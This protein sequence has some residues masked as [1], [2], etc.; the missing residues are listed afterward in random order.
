[1]IRLSP[2]R[3]MTLIEALISIAVVALVLPIAIAGVSRAVQSAEQVRRMDIARRLVETR[4]ALLAADGS[5][6]SSATSGDFDPRVDGDDAAGFHWQLT[7]TPWRDPVVRTLSLTVS[8]TSS[9]SQRALTM[10]T[11]ATPPA[12]P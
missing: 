2:R 11:M 12:T 4:L 10:E 6:Q 1:M 9:G 8:W 7:V 5:W 3:G